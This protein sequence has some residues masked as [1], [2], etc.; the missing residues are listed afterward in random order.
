M[1]SA[2]RNQDVRGLGA[3]VAQAAPRSTQVELMLSNL[4]EE[5]GFLE[6]ATELH[7]NKIAPVLR[8]EAPSVKAG[9]AV[10]DKE[11]LVPVA[12]SIRTMAERVAYARRRVE[13]LTER[14]EA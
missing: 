6:K 4:S 2:Q 13:N 12:D 1:N 8:P 14:T 11:Y 3:S 7:I 5:I 9:D 10:P